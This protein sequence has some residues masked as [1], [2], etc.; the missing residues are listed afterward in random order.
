MVFKSLYQQQNSLASCSKISTLILVL[1]VF[2]FTFLNKMSF[3]LFIILDIIFWLPVIIDKNFC[4]LLFP[5]FLSPPMPPVW[6]VMIFSTLLGLCQS[7]SLRSQEVWRERSF[8][9]CTPVVLPGAHRLTLFAGLRTICCLFS[10]V[11]SPLSRAYHIVFQM[12]KCAHIE[13]IPFLSLQPSLPE[14][15]SFLSPLSRSI[16]SPAAQLSSGDFPWCYQGSLSLFPSPGLAWCH[17]SNR[18][19]AT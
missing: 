14:S 1:L 8:P 18:R 19:M 12:V 17:T 13:P 5:T 2:L 11:P 3:L 15:S 4:L 10:S 16:S 9:S 7:G 6:Y